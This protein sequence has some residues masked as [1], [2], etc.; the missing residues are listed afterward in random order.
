MARKGIYGQ[1]LL[2]SVVFGLRAH[3]TRSL[4]ALCGRLNLVLFELFKT[5]RKNFKRTQETCR[6]SDVS[7]RPSYGV[8]E[9]EI[10]VSEI[11]VENCAAQQSASKNGMNATSFA[12]FFLIE[13]ACRSRQRWRRTGNKPVKQTC[14][15]RLPNAAWS[16]SVSQDIPCMSLNAFRLPMFP[17]CA[18]E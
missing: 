14:K 4:K 16:V 11:R 1:R 13:K 6:G 17:L 10:I 5:S 18:S 8:S 12:R 7:N 3:F 15:A 2:E 9:R